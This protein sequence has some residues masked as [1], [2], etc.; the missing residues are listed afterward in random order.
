M[1]DINTTNQLLSELGGETAVAS[2][3]DL[4]KR[5]L[6]KWL[7]TGV[8]PKSRWLTLY[9]ALMRSGRTFNPK[10]LGMSR[11]EFAKLQAASKT[12]Y[13]I[14]T[15]RQLVKEL[16][17][18]A[19]LGRQLDMTK[20]AI[21][22]WYV[23]NHIQPGWH[24]RFYIEMCRRQKTINPKVFGMTEKDFAPLPRLRQAR[25]SALV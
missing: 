6:N 11:K 5:S 13:D 19:E 15:V 7:K 20:E 22:H 12:M 23:R 9:V 8:A 17:G 10:L 3:F 18:A 2:D 4:S 14:N 21:E 16:G 1:Y 24:L 25:T